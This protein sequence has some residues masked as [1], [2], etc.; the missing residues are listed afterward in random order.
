LKIS[1]RTVS[2]WAD[3]VEQWVIKYQKQDQLF[4]IDG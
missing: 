1:F 3:V 2:E 4:A